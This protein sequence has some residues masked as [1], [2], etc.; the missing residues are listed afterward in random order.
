MNIK[1]IRTIFNVKEKVKKQF[2]ADTKHFYDCIKEL[3]KEEPAEVV[4]KAKNGRV[5]KMIYKG[6]ESCMYGN[7]E[8]FKSEEEVGSA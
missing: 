1:E 3:F 2:K 6:R 5:I 4:I 7:K 8:L